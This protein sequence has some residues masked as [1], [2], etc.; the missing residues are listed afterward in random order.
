[1]KR[2]AAERQAFVREAV[3]AKRAKMAKN[4]EKRAAGRTAQTT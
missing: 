3:G 2:I 1:L 4:E